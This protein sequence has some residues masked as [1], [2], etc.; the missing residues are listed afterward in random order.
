MEGVVRA[1]ILIL[2]L[3]G[4]VLVHLLLL[5]QRGVIVDDVIRIIIIQ[6]NDVDLVDMIAL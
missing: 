4:A 2:I 3:L 1:L 5:L 6:V